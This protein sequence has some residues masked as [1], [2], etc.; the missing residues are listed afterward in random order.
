MS[1]GNSGQSSTGVGIGSGD[2]FAQSSAR[3]ACVRGGRRTVGEPRTGPA[4]VRRHPSSEERQC[5]RGEISGGGGRH[6]EFMPVDA[7]RQEPCAADDPQEGV[8]PGGRSIVGPPV[9]RRRRQVTATAARR[10]RAWR[11]SACPAPCGPARRIS[12][13]CARAARLT[14]LSRARTKVHDGPKLGG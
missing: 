6:I 10:T 5:R 4:R 7:R 9:R 11:G 12:I 8:S 2:S 3:M 14:S 1:D 13:D